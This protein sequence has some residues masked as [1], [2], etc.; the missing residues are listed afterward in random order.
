MFDVN[1]RLSLI[2]D[3]IPLLRTMTPSRDETLSD[4]S[5]R[6]MCKVFTQLPENLCQLHVVSDRYDGIYGIKDPTGSPV[7]LKDSSGCHRRRGELSLKFSTINSDSIKLGDSWQSILRSSSC[8]ANLVAFIYEF[9]SNVGS[10]SK[11]FDI[12]LAGC[13]PDRRHVGI[14]PPNRKGSLEPLPP[15]SLELA[16]T[17]EEA[18]MPVAVHVASSFRNGSSSVIV[19]AN[20]TNILVILLQHSST[21]LATKENKK[22]LFLQ[23]PDRI[24]PVHELAISIPRDFIDS[25]GLLHCLSGTDTTSFAYSVGKKTFMKAALKF[26]LIMKL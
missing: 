9:W 4:F 13:F 3:F 20:D 10:K 2:L 12:I 22:E 21:L 26:D 7:C 14:L 24:F 15:L 16:S 8:K 1:S 19:W 6:L 5:R 18:D 23:F 25:I 17:H 11:N